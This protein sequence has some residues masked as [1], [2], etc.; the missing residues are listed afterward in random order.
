M[1]KLYI[2]RNTTLSFLLLL[3][4]VAGVVFGYVSLS[5]PVYANEERA[6]RHILTVYDGGS[7][8]GIMTEKETLGEAL[9]EAGIELTEY[10]RV[11]PQRDS[12]LISATYE[13]NIYRARPVAIVDDGI[14]RTKIM[15][16][17]RSALQITKEAGISIVP[18]DIVRLEHTSNLLAEGAL[19]RVVI[20]RAA[21]IEAN[22]YGKDVTLYTQKGTL[23]EVLK[24]NNI[25]MDTATDGIEPAVTTSVYSGMKVRI[26][27]DGKQTITV[28][29]V[30]HKPIKKISDKNEKVGYKKVKTPGKDGKKQ[31]SYEVE[32]RNGTEV[33]RKEIASVV[34]VQPVEEVVIIGAKP[35]APPAYTGGGSK[36]DWLRASGIPQSD[37]QYVDFIVR[38]E[39]GWN[40]NAVNPSSGA[41][42]LAQ[43]LPCGKQKTF[44]AW[45]DPVAN[46]KW[47]HSYVKR[48]YGGYAQAYSFWQRNHWY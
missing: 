25:V 5:S 38:R 1:K 16:A 36:D 19:E 45:N 21:S 37:W 18:Q 13:V 20:D 23:S 14:S 6:T 30:L 11:E 10:D 35:K 29:E 31:V 22:L 39:S 7:Q 4:T 48:R 24:D 40:P 9:E 47:Q 42:G 32:L 26:W 46:L 27:R 15:T 44:G 33:S 17:S 12:Q 2:A 34:T 43:S 41:C 8:K 3:T 28:E